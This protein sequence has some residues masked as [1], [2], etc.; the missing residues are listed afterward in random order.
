[1]TM[2]KLK[3]NAFIIA[4]FVAALFS[5][6]VKSDDTSDD[7]GRALEYMEVRDNTGYS[8]K[9]LYGYTLNIL[10]QLDDFEAK[11]R[12]ALVSYEYDYENVYDNM[13]SLDANI[14]N[15]VAIET[16]DA[17]IEENLMLESNAPIYKIY[18]YNYGSLNSYRYIYNSNYKYTVFF[19]DEFDMILPIYCLVKYESGND[20]TDELNSHSY[21]LTYNIEDGDAS[22]G[23]LV[24]RLVHNVAD[25]SIND[26]RTTEYVSAVHFNLN[27]AI[28]NYAVKYGRKP[29]KLV[30][31]YNYNASGVYDEDKIDEV[32]ID[33]NTVLSEIDNFNK[34]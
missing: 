28:N 9:S 13:S 12:F 20:V 23:E 25:D 7:K 17:I 19:W 30:I 15:A 18:T 32:V 24:F 8:F 26:K 33:Y 14:A 6:C 27:N 16:K 4:S 1:M 21:A 34:N 22:D 5:S 10:N 29:S 2:N 31:K 11:G 3:T